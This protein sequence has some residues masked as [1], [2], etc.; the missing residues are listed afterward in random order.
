MTFDPR[1]LNA[2]R[3]TALIEQLGRDGVDVERERCDPSAMTETATDMLELARL[4]RDEQQRYSELTERTRQ[5]IARGAAA[6]KCASQ[7]DDDSEVRATHALANVMHWLF[8]EQDPDGYDDHVRLAIVAD[9]VAN[10]HDHLVV[11][12]LELSGKVA[13]A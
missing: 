12:I 13:A 2:S 3:I 1:Q 7:E 8:A 11:E 6:V 4:L 10:A 9:V 5:R